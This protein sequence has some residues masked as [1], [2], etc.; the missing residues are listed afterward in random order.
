MGGDE[1]GT[2]QFPGDV[3]KIDRRLP[4]GALFT[5]NSTQYV[6]PCKLKLHEEKSKHV[7]LAQQNGFV[8]ALLYS[9]LSSVQLVCWGSYKARQSKAYHL[10]E[11]S[12]ITII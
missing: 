2:K 1:G 6:I 12:A 5:A 8:P 4:W 10:P 9:L 7:G 3:L 11:N